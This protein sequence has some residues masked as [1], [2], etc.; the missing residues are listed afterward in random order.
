M[1]EDVDY[2]TYHVPLPYA[3]HGYIWPFVL[4]YLCLMATWTWLYGLLEQVEGMLIGF[5]CIGA[6]NIVA[7]LCCVWSV[8]IR[9]KLTCSK[10]S[11]YANLSPFSYRYSAQLEA[12]MP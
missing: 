4:A 12:V 7:C 9:C 8:H 1:S 11:Y 6:L 3:F 2:A 5:A 10:V